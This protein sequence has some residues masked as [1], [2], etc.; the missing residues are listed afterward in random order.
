MLNSSKESQTHSVGLEAK[1]LAQFSRLFPI[2]E[3]VLHN[4]KESQ[5]H[6]EGLEVKYL[7]PLSGLSPDWE[8]ERVCVTQ[9]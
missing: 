9:L 5:K 3:R 1:Y 7:A 8:R 4:S 6:S 2:W